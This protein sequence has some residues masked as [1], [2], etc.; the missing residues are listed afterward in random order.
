MHRHDA[1]VVRCEAASDHGHALSTWYLVDERLHASLCM[2]CGDMDHPPE[3][4]T[5][6][7]QGLD[8]DYRRWWRLIADLMA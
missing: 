2:K 8:S 6:A 3:S 7:I 5:T 4:W 1:A